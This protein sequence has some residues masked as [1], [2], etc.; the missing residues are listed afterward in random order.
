MRTVWKAPGAT[1]KEK[2]HPQHPERRELV[3]DRTPKSD[4]KRLNQA[5]NHTIRLRVIG[6]RH[7]V[8]NTQ[9]L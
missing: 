2:V 4:L 5:F 3:L 1:N 9:K 6:R 8:I 7:M